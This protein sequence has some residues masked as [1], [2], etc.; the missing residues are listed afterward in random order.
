MAEKGLSFQE[1]RNDSEFSSNYCC[2]LKVTRSV[3]EWGEGVKS[4][5]ILDKTVRLNTNSRVDMKSRLILGK[6]V[7]DWIQTQKFM[8]VIARILAFQG[9]ISPC[10]SCYLYLC[11]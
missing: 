11:L 8:L 7:L 3:E 1:L 5:K 6:A 10:Y 4:R 2:K 9:R